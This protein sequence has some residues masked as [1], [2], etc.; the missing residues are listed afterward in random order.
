MKS[1]NYLWEIEPQGRR[2]K[3]WDGFWEASVTRV[4]VHMG[5]KEMGMQTRHR[6]AYNQPLSRD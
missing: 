1:E 6:G 4:A 3:Y 2:H 5:V